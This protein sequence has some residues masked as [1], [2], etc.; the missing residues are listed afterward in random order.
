MSQLWKF[1]KED[2]IFY[3]VI[4]GDFNVNI[5]P[6]KSLEELHIGTH[7]LEWNE[8]GERLPELIISTKT[9]HGN[10]QFQRPFSLRWTWESPDGQFHNKVDHI[11]FNRKY[12]MTDVYVVSKFYTG[13]DYRLL[14]ARTTINWNLYTSLAGLWEDAVMDNVDEKYDRFVHYLRDR[15]LAYLRVAPATDRWS[16][17]ELNFTKTMFMKNG[18]VSDAPFSLNGTNISECSSYVYLGREV[19]M[20]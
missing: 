7:G 10:S 16:D 17:S 4:D 11:I 19:N 6:R 13:S 2:H 15:H 20:A 8:Q 1:Y 14:R 12:C 9:I 18:Q 5:G 3:K